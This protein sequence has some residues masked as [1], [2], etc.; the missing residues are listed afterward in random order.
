MTEKQLRKFRSEVVD[1]L[2][3]WL[4]ELTVLPSHRHGWARAKVKGCRSLIYDIGR[5]IRDLSA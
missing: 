3:Y 5:D 1:D 2:V 4:H